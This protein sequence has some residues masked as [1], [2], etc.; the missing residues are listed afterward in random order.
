MAPLQAHVSENGDSGSKSGGVRK[1]V[2]SVRVKFLLLHLLFVFLLIPLGGFGVGFVVG[3]ALE[4][5]VG[6]V[7]GYFIS[8]KLRDAT[9]M[10]AFF[11]GLVLFVA[12]AS[13]P[14]RGWDP[15]IYHV[16]RWQYFKDTM[17][18]LNCGSQECLYTV[19]TV[20]LVCGVSYSLGSFLGLYGSQIVTGKNRGQT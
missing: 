20:W 9:A 8:I 11:P 14:L 15:S 2:T 17:F 10:F 16:S 12:A 7:V 1:A 13:D 5:T 6:L 4:C 18:G 3:F 19:F